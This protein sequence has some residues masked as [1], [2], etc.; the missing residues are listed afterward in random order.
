MQVAATSAAIMPAGAAALSFAPCRRTSA[1]MEARASVCSEACIAPVPYSMPLK[2][3]AAPPPLRCVL[4][5]GFHTSL[6]WSKTSEVEG[7]DW[8]AGHVSQHPATWPARY[9][10]HTG[11]P[12]IAALRHSRVLPKS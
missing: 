6:I 10:F 3:P 4:S 11:R 5:V 9:A 8:D 1:R 7:V 12:R 2:N